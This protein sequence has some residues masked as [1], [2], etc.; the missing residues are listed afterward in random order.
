MEVEAA[1]VTVH[2]AD[3]AIQ[4]TE[5][6]VFMVTTQGVDMATTQDQLT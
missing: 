5:Q 3:G 1:P 2:A 6:G 4:H